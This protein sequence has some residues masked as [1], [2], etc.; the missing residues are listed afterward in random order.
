VETVR[1]PSAVY[2]TAAWAVIGALCLA[3]GAWVL[4]WW[5]A[6]GGLRLMPT[7]KV[8]G[9]RGAALW[10]VQVLVAL[11]AAQLLRHAVRSSRREGRI[12]L[13]AA[14]AFGLSISF[15]QNPL[16]NYARPALTLNRAV[17]SVP[18]WGPHIMGWH[19]PRPGQEREHL[20][21]A[22]GPLAYACTIML[23]WMPWPVIR[24]V[25]QARP[26]WNLGKIL[27][28][29][30]LLGVAADL[31]IEIPWLLI[32]GYTFNSAPADLSL[33]GGHWYQIPLYEIAMCTVIFTLPGIY[34]LERAHRNDA[35]S[36]LLAG[37]QNSWVRLLAGAGFCNLACL[38]YFIGMNL[39]L[40]WH[41]GPTPTGTPEFLGGA[42]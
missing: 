7:V 41:N 13:F 40:A 19:N 1:Q 24:R 21:L 23:I 42:D 14:L 20:L 3:Y 4:G 39:L 2:I 28:L 15:W 6:D 26:H 31:V 12:S 10:T 38:L 33:F 11:S 27:C 17:L 30:A 22:G 9:T 25:L 32:G 5:A 29:A 16:F 35:D 18:T 37:S 34:L 8:S 36:W